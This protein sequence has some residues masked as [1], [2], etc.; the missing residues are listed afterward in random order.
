MDTYDI[1]NSHDMFHTLF[2]SLSDHSHTWKTEGSHVYY[3]WSMQQIGFFE[4][5]K[6]PLFSLRNLIFALRFIKD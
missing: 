5:T 3:S 1:V 4:F 2:Y 6:T